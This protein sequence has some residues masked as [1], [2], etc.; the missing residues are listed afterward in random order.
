VLFAMTGVDSSNLIDSPAASKLGPHRAL[1]YTEEQGRLEKF[2]PYGWP[3]AEW[4]ASMTGQ[5]ASR[6]ATVQENADS[7]SAVAEGA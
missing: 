6:T 3:A 7:A 5:F 1:L 2:R 4:L